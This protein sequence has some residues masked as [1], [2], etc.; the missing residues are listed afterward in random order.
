MITQAPR[1]LTLN[2][3]F[4]VGVLLGLCCR[5]YSCFVCAVV[6]MCHPAV[7]VV[8]DHVKGADDVDVHVDV[9]IV[10]DL[11]RCCMFSCCSTLAVT[12]SYILY[13]SY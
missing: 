7:P 11:S 12:S 1:I 6:V 3:R 4:C 8:F 13:T 10:L 5:C 2:L 9:L